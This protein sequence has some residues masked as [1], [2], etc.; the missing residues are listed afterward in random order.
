MAQ[1]PSKIERVRG[2]QETTFA[3]QILQASIGNFFEIPFREGT[4][5]LKLN[6]PVESPMHARQ[7]MDGHPI[8]VLMPRGATF[9]FTCNLETI[10]TKATSTVAP[11]NGWLGQLLEVAFGG[12]NLTTGTFITGAG[13]TVASFPLSVVTTIHPGGAIGMATGAGSTLECRELATKSSNTYVP[14]LAVTSAPAASLTVYGAASYYPDPYMDGS[15]AKSLQ[16]LVEGVNTEDRWL[17]LGG[18]LDSIEITTAVGAIPTVKFAWKFANHLRADQTGAPFGTTAST[19]IL[20]NAVALANATYTNTNTLVVV[21][22]EFRQQTVGTSTLSAATLVHAPTI[23]WKLN[24]TWVA[25]R[26]PAGTQTVKQWVRTHTPP[27]ISGSF[28]VPFEAD[29]IWYTARDTRLTKMLAM[30]IGT[31]AST[32]AVLMVAPTVQITDVQ[33]EEIDGVIGTRVTWEGRNDE[34]T[35]AE[36]TFESISDA[37]F[38]IHLF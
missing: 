35:T 24:I 12:K 15:D 11:A 20:S 13:A 5:V 1:F 8:G 36:S 19:G 38:R 28:T 29:L 26:T 6:Q 10:T 25:H 22:S 2:I 18:A 30:Q 32:G 7:K 14:K 34:S 9:E 21:D 23:E 33:R 31:A 27:L 4:A 37:A 3:T 17:L 16:L